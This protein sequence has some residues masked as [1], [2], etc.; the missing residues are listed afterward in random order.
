ML[1]GLSVA[2]LAYFLFTWMHV[3]LITR[4]MM[5]WDQARQLARA[6]HIVGSHTMTH[7]NMAHVKSD[8]D[9]QQ[10]FE[11]SKRRL[12]Q[13]L[14]APVVHFSYPCPILQPHWTERTVNMCRQ[15]GYRTAVTTNPGLARR[16]NDP[17]TLRRGK[18]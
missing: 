6:G 9:L 14:N 2:V 18:V 7:P 8:S 15:L 4:L 12:E 11:Q 5:S 13:E 16:G 17:L 1:I 3:K 10:E